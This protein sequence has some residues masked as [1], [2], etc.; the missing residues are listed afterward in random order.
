MHAVLILQVLLITLPFKNTAAEPSGKKR[1]PVSLDISGHVPARI[2]ALSSTEFPGGIHYTA[3]HGCSNTHIV[4]TV[5]DAGEHIIGSDPDA[6][7]RYVLVVYKEDG[8]KYVR[9]TTRYRRNSHIFQTKIMEFK[10]IPLDP[11]YAQV[12]RLSVELNIMD[13]THN[14]YIKVETVDDPNGR[15]SNI[16]KFTIKKNVF[17]QVIIGVVRYG[18][19]QIDDKTFGLVSKKVIWNGNTDYPKISIESL[20]KNGSQYKID[21]VPCEELTKGFC[22]AKMEKRLLNLIG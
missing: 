8:S 20:H 12:H 11:H 5:S 2:R 15:P 14:R 22:I 13:N 16:K 21:Y 9:V 10:T 6:M 1:I 17:D 3:I 7:S 4:G 18:K 19:H